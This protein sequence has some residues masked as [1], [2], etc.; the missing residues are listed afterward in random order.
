[1]AN[2]NFAEIKIG[3]CGYGYYDPG[4]DWEERYKSKLQAYTDSFQTVEI[5]KTFYQ[6]P[7][8]KTAEKW[9]N[10]AF[11][12]FEFNLKAWQALTH[13]T[14]SP[15]WR[16]KKDKLSESQKESFGY[17]RPNK[18]VVKA[19]ED[20]KEIAKALD[21]EIVVIQTPGSFDCCSKNE[22][23]MRKLFD[24]IEREGLN[25]AWEPR[26][27]WK[28]N[29]ERVREICRDL[30][31]IHIVDLMRKEPLSDHKIAYTRLHGLN[32]D[33]YDYNYDYSDEEL[34]TLAEKLE[35]LA[36][37]HSRVY[38]MFNNYQMFENTAKLKEIL[39]S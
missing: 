20:T 1:M 34:K 11:E 35:E 26:G 19:W 8:K 18:E 30:D 36:V 3:T 12:D 28:E 2:E 31:L 4:E 33:R 9:R 15:T 22:E 17:L 16:N 5:N 14:S 32:P 37:E 25:I 23:N 38:C 27:D 21:G 13:P 10:N 24:K 29:P 39:S 7:M 6:L